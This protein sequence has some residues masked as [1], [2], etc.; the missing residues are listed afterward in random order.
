MK[1]LAN[2]AAGRKMEV[3]CMDKHQKLELIQRSLGIR[4]KLKVHESMKSPDTHEELALMLLSKWEL[5][6][7]LRAIEDLLAEARQANVLK[8]KETIQKRHP[9]IEVDPKRKAKE[10]SSVEPVQKVY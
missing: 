7:E 6:D 2:L 8:K 9:V 3:C 4:H 5:E 1:I 10:L